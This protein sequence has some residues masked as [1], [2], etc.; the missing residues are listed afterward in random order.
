LLGAR[1]AAGRDSRDEDS[2]PQ[3]RP[4]A[5]TPPPARLPTIAILSYG[6]WQ[7]HFGGDRSIVGQSIDFLGGRVQVVGVLAPDFE[8]LFAPRINLERVP[9]VWTALRVDF[10][11]ASRINVFLRIIGRL[12]P[13]VTI[14]QAQTQINKIASDLQDRFPIKKTANWRMRLEPM[15]DDLVKDVQPAILTLLGAVLFVLLIACANVANLLLV[16]ASARER[17]LSIRAAIGGSQWRLV[18]QLLAE[19][20]VLS[21]GGALLGLLFAQLGIRLLMALEPVNLPR[22]QAIRIDHTVLAFTAAVA[23]VSAVVF[24]LVPAIRASRPNVMDVLRQ[25]GSSGLRAGRT[26]RSAVVMTEVALSFALLVG[27]GL[28]VRSFIALQH[29]DPGF[30]PNGLLTFIVQPQGQRF[31]QPDARAAFMRELQDKLGGVPGVEAVSATALLPL[32]GNQGANC[33]WGTE[34]ALVDATKFRQADAH[35]VLPGYFETMRTR[36]IE[37]RTFTPADNASA[38]KLVIIDGLLAAKAFPGQSALGKHIYARLTTNTPED[39]TVIGVVRHERPTSLAQD[40]REGL[41]VTD[42][43]FGHGN[44]NRWIVRTT[45]DP[46]R[47]ATAIKAEI[48]KVDKTALVADMQPMQVFVDRSMVST[49]FALTLI[50]VFAVIAVLLAAIG[51]YGVLST[52]VRQRTAEIGVRI[53]FGASNFSILKLVIGQGLRLS[54]V[55]IV[56]GLVAAFSLTRFMASLLVGVKPTDP[57]TFATIA[58]LFFVI[59]MLASWLPARRSAALDPTMALREE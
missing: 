11:T 5:N 4:Q 12:K 43:Y 33:R 45:G 57:A 54:A 22:L 3:Q 59:A 8:L 34:E 7:R 18:R 39:F 50:G 24:G 31:A 32:D 20:L 53:A 19:S 13:N 17:E 6:Y 14:A 26:L 42:G 28:M 15:H 44:A 29:A 55:G 38:E 25:T 46:A 52:A 47:L 41:Y 27:A 21:I 23:V 9:D 30:E 48:A 49:R 2:V 35:G 36:I 58:V 56:L 16:R 37:G 51:L 10:D 40:G 1:M